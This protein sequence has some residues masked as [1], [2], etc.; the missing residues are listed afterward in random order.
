[1][2]FEDI[3][4]LKDSEGG[5]RGRVFFKN[6]YGISVV[7]N[8]YSYG[9][10]KGLYEIAVLNLDGTI[11]YDSS[12]TQDVVGWLTQV[13]VQDFINQIENLPSKLN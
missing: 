8:K 13:Q 1:M 3:N 12:V 9:N 7:C 6:G 5:V 4:F 10:E 2:K 11:C